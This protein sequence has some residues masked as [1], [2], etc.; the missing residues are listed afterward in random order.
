ARKAVAS[1]RA[2]RRPDEQILMVCCMAM[3]VYGLVG[4]KQSAHELREIVRGYLA[5]FARDP[6]VVL[7][8]LQLDAMVLSWLHND[9][10]GAAL[11]IRQALELGRL[12][13]VELLDSN[14]RFQG[15]QFALGLGD[16]AG[17]RAL[18]GPWRAQAAAG[19]PITRGPYAYASGWYAFERGDLNDA[20]H[21]LEQSLEDAER[22][23]ATVP[24]ILSVAGICICAAA[25]GDTDRAHALLRRLAEME[26]QVPV[27]AL[28]VANALTR[29]YVSV[30]AGSPARAELELAI[31]LAAS[32]GLAPCALFTQS[33]LKRLVVAA[34]EA[35]IELE[36][37]RRLIGACAIQPG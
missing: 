9:V 13:G 14:L 35:G 18:L 29:A 4:E 8:G 10:A 36:A 27:R 19:S 33:V 3:M 7:V 25:R 28:L 31:R 5:S 30:S 32:E 21:Y 1:L 6:L 26:R 17:C 15:A 16:M 12:N 22:L 23:S 34:L 20:E 37:A 11:A 2:Y 24:R